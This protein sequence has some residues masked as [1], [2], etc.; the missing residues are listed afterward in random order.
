MKDLFHWRTAIPCLST[1]I[2]WV[3]GFMSILMTI[4]GM[5]T[6]QPEFFRWGA[7]LVLLAL[8]FDGLDGNLARL[9]KGKSDFGA[10]L[11]T[12]VDLTAF[13]VA[14]AVL[15]HAVTL[16]DMALGWRVLLPIYVGLSGAFRLARFKV[17]DPSRGMGG[18]TGLP[19]TVNAIWVSL[20][21]LVMI[22]PPARGLTGYYQYFFLFGVLVLSSLQVSL[23]HYPALSKKAVYFIPGI[24]AIF[25]FVLLNFLHEGLAR[26]WALFLAGLCLAYVLFGPLM[27]RKPRAGGESADKPA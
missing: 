21:V 12:F 4:Q 20:F 11:D 26:G 18:Y 15:I 14:P 3:A 13:G 27:T 23:V 8:V 7:I 9:L 16:Q 24:G 22:I 25:L 10:E 19:I 6:G 2:A 17:I 1:I 5:V